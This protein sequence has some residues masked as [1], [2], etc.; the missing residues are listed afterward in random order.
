MAD[1]CQNIIISPLLMQMTH[2]R[3]YIF[4]SFSGRLVRF[5]LLATSHVTLLCEKLAILWPSAL[6][7][8]TTIKAS[9]NKEKL[10]LICGVRQ[11]EAEA[12]K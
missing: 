3:L 1:I 5:L 6:L 12:A 2:A 10:F 11:I 9:T 8:V 4:F 7:V